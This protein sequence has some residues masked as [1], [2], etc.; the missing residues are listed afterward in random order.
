VSASSV[1]T[2]WKGLVEKLSFE[3]IQNTSARCFNTTCIRCCP[4]RA[5]KNL[6]ISINFQFSSI[7]VAG[8]SFWWRGRR[9]KRPAVQQQQNQPPE[10]SK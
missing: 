2:C 4:L 9:A 7:I 6:Q 10:S 3:L 8:D 1:V 5:F